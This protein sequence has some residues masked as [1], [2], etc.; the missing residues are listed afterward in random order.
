[1][2]NFSKNLFLYLLPTL[3][4]AII[5]IV[6]LPIITKY[7]SL[8]E[9]GIYSLILVYSIFISGIANFGLT[10]GFEREY[11][12]INDNEKRIGLLYTTLLVVF[13]TN[14]FFI[15]ITIAYRETI[16]GILL[17][18]REYGKLIVIATLS[19][20]IQSLKFYF[21]IYFKNENN[22][23]LYSWYT[24]DENLLST[25]ISMTLIVFFHQGVF[26]L[27]I[28][29]LVAGSIIFIILM[30][31][32]LRKHPF[33]C[34]FSDFESSLKISLPLTPKIFFG[35]IG[36]QFDKFLIGLMNSVGGAGIYSLG[37]KISNLSYTFLT[38]LQNIFSPKVYKLMFDE[39]Y[40]R[41]KKEI[42]QYLLPFFY[43][44][45]CATLVISI[46][47]EEVIL[48]LTSNNYKEAV[49]VNSILSMLNLT[50]FF[51]KIP[52]L[53][54]AKKT[55]LSSFLNI[56]GILTNILFNVPLIYKFG[57]LGA[58]C[59]T[60]LSG[61]IINFISFFVYQKY[62]RIDWDLNKIGL[63]I[64]VSYTFITVEILTRLY[65]IQYIYRISM[66]LFFIILFLVLGR[67]FK[68]F[69]I[70]YLL[71]IINDFQRKN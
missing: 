28:G 51:G 41:G 57:I 14:F 15:I 39:D 68:I 32:F 71:K 5:P 52:Q 6:T 13:L 7:I 22:A 59:G 47:G 49:N 8:H 37:Q 56:L 25:A 67:Y 46:F 54:F 48:L 43:L 26:G 1:M 42:G 9:F 45:T 29:Q 3:V 20:G 40:K 63:I 21:L 23:K 27:I 44:S 31:N 4:G 53:I 16:S 61:F 24:I 17:R 36:S 58:A 30:V 66:K 60:F 18:T 55:W 50:F 19:S 62:Y 70:S 38:A 10:A 69:K 11:F 34:N 33:K 65:D 2:N 35:V 12:S 64:I